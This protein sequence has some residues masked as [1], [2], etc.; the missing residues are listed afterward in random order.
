V[1]LGTTHKSSGWLASSPLRH[2]T[3][4]RLGATPTSPHGHLK[5]EIVGPG[6]AT[7]PAARLVIH[8][9]GGGATMQRI[10]LV[11]GAAVVTKIPF[12]RAGIARVDVILINASTRYTCNR[13][14]SFSCGGTPTDNR[15]VFRVKVTH[16]V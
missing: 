9:V 12:N 5:V 6:R 10:K 13:G 3:S 16:T 11:R 14:T 1:H 4:V 15:S 2:L 8:L 7:V